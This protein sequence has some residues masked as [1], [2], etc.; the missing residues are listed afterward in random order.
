MLGADDICTGGRAVTTSRPGNWNR[1][2]SLVQNSKAVITGK[3]SFKPAKSQKSVYADLHQFDT[4]GFNF[5]NPH[6]KFDCH[7]RAPSSHSAPRVS[8]AK[9]F[10]CKT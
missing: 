10:K 7:S 9:S 2:C 3:P 1:F 5:P 4:K 8:R 6:K